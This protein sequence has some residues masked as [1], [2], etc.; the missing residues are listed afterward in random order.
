MTSRTMTRQ[1]NVDDNKKKG[2]KMRCDSC[3]NN[4]KRKIRIQ[5][6][7]SDCNDMKSPS[8]KSSEVR[9]GRIKVIVRKRPLNV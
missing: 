4:N 1:N 8:E 6:S 7:K 5:N 3:S 2:M 9:D